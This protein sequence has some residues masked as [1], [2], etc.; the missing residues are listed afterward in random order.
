MSDKGKLSRLLIIS[1]HSGMSG[2]AASH[3]IDDRLPELLRQGVDCE[4][5]SSVCG[6]K[7]K[8]VKHFRIISGLFS[9][10]RYEIRHFLRQKI[11]HKASRKA[12]EIACMIPILIPYA[13]EKLFVRLD[14]TWSW[15]IFTAPFGVV[16]VWIFK[17]EAIYV[18]GGAVASHAA[19]VLISRLTGVPLISEFQ[20]PIVYQLNPKK[21]TEKRYNLWLEKVVA[22]Y[23][24]KLIFLTKN[25]AKAA[26]ERLPEYADKI[27]SIYPGLTPLDKLP[28]THSNNL[29]ISHFGTLAGSRNLDLLIESLE[30]LNIRSG[31]EVHLYGH[32]DKAVKDSI[33]NSGI[34]PLFKVFGKV[35]REVA[36]VSMSGADVLLLMQNKDDVSI[37]T[38]PSKVYEYMQTGKLILSFS[39]RNAELDELL[40]RHGHFST[41]LQDANVCKR[42]IKTIVESDCAQLSYSVK[43][44]NYGLSE[45]VS[46]LVDEIVQI[47]R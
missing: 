30:F 20:D 31:V 47:K 12:V 14:A 25:A 15:F 18:T 21:K 43:D 29:V 37:Q 6:I 33:A 22:K 23:A 42:L 26:Q 2:S 4:L 27:K 13:I 3:H 17:P 34:A 35:S 38:I 45:C 7:S 41:D 19:G 10:W 28:A 5:I 46:I 40:H 24:S 11:S 9:G 39:Y 36:L 8:H 16:R 1:Y 32:L 44:Y